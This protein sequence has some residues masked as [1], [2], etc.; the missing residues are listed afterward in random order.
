MEKAINEYVEY[1]TFKFGL[2]KAEEINLPNKDVVV[3]ATEL[4]DKFTLE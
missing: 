1:E 3:K 2:K 4:F